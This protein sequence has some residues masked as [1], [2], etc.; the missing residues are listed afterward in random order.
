MLGVKSLLSLLK[1]VALTTLIYIL[2]KV[3][4]MI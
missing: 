4:I 2:L 1:D 3:R